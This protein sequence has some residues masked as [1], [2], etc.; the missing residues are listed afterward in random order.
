MR[1]VV[2]RVS[3]AHVTVGGDQVGS[4]ERGLVVLLGVETGDTT[5][6]ADYIVNKIVGLRVFEDSAALMNLSLLDL[7]LAVLLISQFT[8]LGDVRRGK[9]PSF[10]TAAAPALA[11]Q[12]Y[13]YCQLQLLALGVEVATGVFRA[14]MQVHLTNDGPVTILIDSRKLF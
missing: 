1:C 4:I 7:K 12:L 8:L 9:R 13:N 10:I 2:Q 3:Q 6:D 11:E 5:A 14:D